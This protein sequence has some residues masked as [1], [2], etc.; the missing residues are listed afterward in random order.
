[1]VNRHPDQ[2]RRR[3][4]QTASRLRSLA[5][6]AAVAPDELLVSERTGRI[7]WAAA[8]ELAYRPAQIGEA[9]GPQWA[10]FW[11]RIEATIPPEW[12]ERRVD[13]VWDSGSEATLWCDGAPVQGLNSHDRA[14]RREAPLAH[15][16][17]HVSLQ[18][19]L[20]CNDWMGDPDPFGD[21]RYRRG[22]TWH[23]PPDDRSLRPEPVHARLARCGLALFDPDAWELAWDFEA[24]RQLEAEHGLDP[25]WAGRLLAGL[26]RFCNVWRAA[27][28]GTWEPARELLAELLAHRNGGRAHEVTAIGHAHLDS[29]WLWPLAESRRKAI[30]SFANQLA[31]MERYPEH[32]F[33]ASSAQHYAWL[34]EDAPDLYARVRE[35]VREGRWEVVGG[36]WVEPDCNLPSGESLVRQLLY[37]QR[38][39]QQRFGL[40]CREYWSPDTFG[41]NG[42]LPQ[43]LRGAGIERFLTQKLS[44][45]QFTQPPHH[46]FRWEGI[47][48]SAVLAHMPPADTYN[49]ELTVPELRASAARFKDHDRTAASLLVFGH[50]DGG[51]GPTA[52]MLELAR[53]TGD[54]Q[55][56]PRV[57]LGTSGEFFERLAEELTDPPTIAGELYFEYHRGT[58]TSQAAAKRGNREGERLLHEAEAAAALAN[59]LSGAPYPA[60][61]LRELWQRLLLNQFHDILPGSSIGAVYEDAARDHAAVAEGAA[62]LRDEAIG[63]LGGGGPPAPL[64]LTPFARTEVTDELV[65]V[66]APAYGF[67]AP[68][69]PEDEVRVEGLVLENRQ[70]RASFDPEGRLVSLVHD[71]REALS[72]PANVFELSDDRPTAYDAWELEPYTH[73]T[74]RALPGAHAHHVVT[75]HPLRGE[76]AFEHRIG[77]RSTLRQTVRLH[78][79]ARR[80]EFRT[81]VDWAERNRFLQVAFPL[82]V[83]S[84][85]ATYE[86][87][88]G[89]AERPTHVNTQADLARFEVPGHRFAD[90]SEHGFGV[91]LL[92][93]STYGYAA[94]G[95]VMR[96]S[97]LRGATDP[98]PEADAGRHDFG[99][100]VMPHGGGWQ[101]AGVVAEARTFAEPLVAARGSGAFAAVDAPGLVLDTIKRAEDSDAIVL[102]LYEA[103]GARGSARV[104]LRV[105]FSQARRANLL[106][107]EGDELPVRDGAIELDYSP[108]EL[109]TVAVR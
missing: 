78:A 36:A 55:G 93:D 19:E 57:Q 9:F 49:A 16:G 22:R 101:E 29:A 86:M 25:A 13:L 59:R 21:A 37:G 1:M 4:E 75:A 5:Y 69:Q 83:R 7:G 47:D 95:D 43:I 77:E 79:H 23:E 63:V 92:T 61:E 91:A 35:R 80:L 107:D 18:V 48:G 54:L 2:T 71:G 106:E 89:V 108:F 12:A 30:R 100:A 81:T 14:Q 66:H 68:A 99:Y 10:T 64:N 6:P 67:G 103:H 33:A 109:I 85:A 62:R 11:F 32:R 84:P 104:Q 26:N 27:D 45:N 52:E 3:I 50:G 53:R 40:R 17:G 70:L 46:S 60:G 88:F 87:Q 41:H 38:A 28:R 105:P 51:G 94:R 73:E 72:G 98:D 39:F 24:L 65:V 90:L 44:W 31:L 15:A 82:A 74:R 8:Q 42:Q 76:L 56:V 102:R 96:L 97:L 20:A 58:Y 34:E